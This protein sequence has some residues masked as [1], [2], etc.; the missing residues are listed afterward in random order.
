MNKKL[1]LIL[2]GSAIS[3]NSYAEGWFI[4]GGAGFVTF[5]DSVDKVSPLNAYAKGGFAFNQYFDAGLEASV[6]LIPDEVYSVDFDVNIVTI[7][8]RVGAPVNDTT[9]IYAQIGNSNTEVTGTYGGYS[10][11]VDD[12]DTSMAFGVQIDFGSNN[13]YF[14]INYSSYF[15]DSGAEAT[16]FNIGVGARM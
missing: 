5:D 11:S 4:G 13:T 15:D 10:L 7:F 12:S 8:M 1:L 16:A 3:M 9:K 14:D 2:L 6:T